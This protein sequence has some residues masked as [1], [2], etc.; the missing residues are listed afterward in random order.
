MN[1]EQ[2]MIDKSK[3][4]FDTSFLIRSWEGTSDKNGRNIIDAE[5]PLHNFDRIIHDY[6]IDEFFLIEDQRT[7]RVNSYEKNELYTMRST[8]EFF[9]KEFILKTATS[10]LDKD[11]MKNFEMLGFLRHQHP[12]QLEFENKYNH[13][14][15]DRQTAKEACFKLIGLEHDSHV[16]LSLSLLKHSLG[17]SIENGFQIDIAGVKEIIY[18]KGNLFELIHPLKEREIIKREISAI[19]DELPSLY[20]FLLFEK[21]VKALKKP[22]N[23]EEFKVELPGLKS[24]VK[25][26]YNTLADSQISLSGLHY[27]DCFATFDKGQAQ[28]IKFLFPE[29]MHKIKLYKADKDQNT[30]NRIDL[31]NL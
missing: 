10:C 18:A 14:K 19:K 21:F 2:N 7:H 3:V 20:Q 17:N 27:C 26:D 28:I 16:K 12:R 29:Y 9:L 13:I 15:K 1:R 25:I 31:E 30:Y 22:E 4:I 11:E 23:K 6:V 5:F 24:H 8:H